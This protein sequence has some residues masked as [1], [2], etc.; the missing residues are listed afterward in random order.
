MA[1]GMQLCSTG[2]KKVGDH[3]GVR[4]H[5]RVAVNPRHIPMTST[6]YDVRSTTETALGNVG[7]DIKTTQFQ[8]P[9]LKVPTS[10]PLYNTTPQTQLNHIL[11]YHHVRQL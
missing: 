3:S 5:E 9:T 1:T 7:M 11:I 6:I 2:A 4:I 10:Q 8:W